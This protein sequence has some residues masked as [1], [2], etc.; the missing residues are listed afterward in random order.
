MA[1]TKF[2]GS[3]AECLS[4]TNADIL[5]VA[6]VHVAYNEKISGLQKRLKAFMTEQSKQ[7]AVNDLK[8]FMTEHSKVNPGTN[9]DFEKVSAAFKKCTEWTDSLN[10]MLEPFLRALINQIVAAA[11]W[12]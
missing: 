1:T 3:Q 5:M 2:L 9:M 6:M 12:W 8:Q 7:F 10:E 11:T 4:S